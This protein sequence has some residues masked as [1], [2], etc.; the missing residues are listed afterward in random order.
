MYG[1]CGEI[2]PARISTRVALLE[3]GPLV[4]RPEAEL[5]Q[6]PYSHIGTLMPD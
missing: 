6:E 1:R 4:A 3:L 2:Y 5:P